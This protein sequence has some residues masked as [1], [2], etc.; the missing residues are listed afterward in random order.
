MLHLPAA[1]VHLRDAGPHATQRVPAQLRSQVASVRPPKL[2]TLMHV[3]LQS[4]GDALCHGQSVRPCFTRPGGGTARD[5][6]AGGSTKAIAARQTNHG[7][8]T[9]SGSLYL[10]LSALTKSWIALHR[11]GTCSLLCRS[12]ELLSVHTRTVTLL[13]DDSSAPPCFFSPSREPQCDV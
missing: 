5:V 6:V 11:L 2:H 13:P 3:Q 10:S 8:R 9:C 7:A 1:T 12:M 4:F